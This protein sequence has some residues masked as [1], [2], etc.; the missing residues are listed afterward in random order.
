MLDKSV[1]TEIK[2]Q[3]A[4]AITLKNPTTNMEKLRAELGS[5]NR[6]MKIS[7]K[8]SYKVPYLAGYM[9]KLKDFKNEVMMNFPK[10]FLRSSSVIIRD[11]CLMRALLMT[12]AICDVCSRVPEILGVRPF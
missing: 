9:M 10:A 11:L 1:E 7:V 3:V 5:D 4:K 2:Q 6:S 8:V 12:F